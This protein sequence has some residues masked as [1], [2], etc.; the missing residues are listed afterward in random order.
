MEGIAVEYFSTSIDTGN[1]EEKYELHSYISDDNE[2]YVC[3]SHAH[4]VNLLEIFLGSGKLVSG[5]STIW[6]DTDVCTKQ[7]MCALAIYLMTVLS[8][9]YGIIMDHAINAPGH[10]NNVV[11]GLNA[12]DK[13]YLKGEI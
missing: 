5:M 13:I 8:Y 12:M 1:N 10:G 4:M 6:E 7:Y 9:S 11:D 2:Q 3:D